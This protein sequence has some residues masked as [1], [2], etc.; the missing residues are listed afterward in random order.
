MRGDDLHRQVWVATYT[1][2]ADEAVAAASRLG[3]QVLLA[4]VRWSAVSAQP[5]DEE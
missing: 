4:Y 3:N 2:P 5:V 1:C